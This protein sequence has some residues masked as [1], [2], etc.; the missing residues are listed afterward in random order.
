[1]T[2]KFRDVAIE[3]E[4]L[5]MGIYIFNQMMMDIFN[6]MMMDLVFTTPMLHRFFEAHWQVGPFILFLIGFLPPLMLSYI[7]NKYKW[8]S[9]T[10]G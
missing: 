1:M 2:G 3:I 10:I 6:Q 4:R 9:W 7:F 5:S 8:L